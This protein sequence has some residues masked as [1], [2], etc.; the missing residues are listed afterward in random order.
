LKLVIW[1]EAKWRTNG[2]HT[3]LVPTS[4][5]YHNVNNLEKKESA[6]M[7]RLSII[8]L[9]LLSF[10]PT[11][12]QDTATTTDPRTGTALRHASAD[13]SFFT[14]QLH[15]KNRLDRL[16]RSKA[17]QDAW[18][19]PLVQAGWD[20]V[21]KQWDEQGGP[22]REALK[23]KE[24]QEALQ[25]L[26]EMA[27]DEVF[28]LCG[29]NTPR[30]LHTMAKGVGAF[31]SNPFTGAFGLD[32]APFVPFRN[33]LREFRNDKANLVVPDVVIGFKIKDPKVAVRQIA[34]LETLLNAAAMAVSELTGKVKHQKI[35]GFDFGTIT[36]DGSMV[37]WDQVPWGQIEEEAGEFKSLIEHLKKLKLTI[38]IG[39]YE[40]YVVIA[41][42][43]STAVIERLGQGKKLAEL[44][45]L[46]PLQKF[47]G[48]P[49]HALTYVSKTL[50]SGSGFTRQD[51][52]ELTKFGREGIDEADS[53]KEEQKKRL[54]K[55]LDELSADLLTLFGH[56]PGPSFSVSFGTPRGVESVHYQYSVD[57]SYDYSKPLTLLH[58]T[59]GNPVAAFVGRAAP[60]PQAWD[61]FVKWCKKGESYFREFAL[62]E[63]PEGN[64]QE[65]T[66]VLETLY[67]FF[68]RFDQTTRENLL[69]ALAD[70][71]IGLVIDNKLF[72]KQWHRSMPA[73]KNPLP[74]LEP[75]LLFG[76]SDADKLQKAMSDYRAIVNGAVKALRE[77]EEDIPED[78][79]W[80]EPQVQKAGEVTM[81]F[82][83]FPDE[84]ELDGRLTPTGAVGKRLASLT[85]SN[86]HALRLMTP[87]P[88]KVEGGPLAELDRPLGG[89]IY[90]KMPALL[91]TARPWV[92][93]V[94]EQ[95]DVK[96]HTEKHAA[97]IKT[98]LNSLRIFDQFTSAT[99]VEGNVTVTHS[100]WV[101]KDER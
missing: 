96:E 29:P 69:P 41:L 46:A 10:T 30:F 57:G 92:D 78:L 38:C 2:V 21:K 52:E 56:E 97:D 66:K 85:V 33:V 4:G 100:E 53:L 44:P 71:Q 39:T 72:S 61:V 19:T 86:E 16:W 93:Y 42:G 50:N 68:R 20:H 31:Q 80:P 67:P 84:L 63:F 82:Y 87:R 55:D 17:V 12:A 51:A 5:E 101:I 18:N 91:D 94:L 64:R 23:Q 47:Q 26:K 49:I 22:F 81:Y 28:I 89:A 32:D 98:I 48:K 74:L 43:E 54:L 3:V 27:S 59:G 76:V 11:L 37:P 25:L 95:P 70:G 75:A 45:E 24:N 35:K 14:T 6:H 1:P 60:K 7:T 83:S 65:V 88:L 79:K 34:R 99:F 15:L 58:H 9:G 40:E 13:A 36:L 90:F 77:V 73:A 8:L 62:P